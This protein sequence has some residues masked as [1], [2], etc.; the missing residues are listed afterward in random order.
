[1]RVAAAPAVRAARD[2]LVAEAA[3]EDF[4]VEHII[5]DVGGEEVVIEVVPR[6]AHIAHIARVVREEEGRTPGIVAIAARFGNA[7]VE[8]VPSD[9]ERFARELAGQ[10]GR[11]NA[12]GAVGTEVVGREDSGGDCRRW[13]LHRP[14]GPR[15]G[16]HARRLATRPSSTRNACRCR[17]RVRRRRCCTARPAD[18]RAR[19]CP[20]RSKG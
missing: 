3:G 6:Q 7:S 9:G 19:W 5:G 14:A 16:R 15:C 17:R 1:M 13:P 4:I 8:L 2:L 11:A 18:R 20:G 10:V 12:G